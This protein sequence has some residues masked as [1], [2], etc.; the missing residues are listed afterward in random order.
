MS[1]FLECVDLEAPYYIGN[2]P[3]VSSVTIEVIPA[4][5]T[6]IVVS[7]EHVAKQAHQ[8][9]YDDRKKVAIDTK[10]RT[11]IVMALPDE[12]K[13]KKIKNHNRKR[14]SMIA[15]DRDWTDSSNESSSDEEDMTYLCLM[16]KIK[17]VKDEPSETSSSTKYSSTSQV[18]QNFVLRRKQLEKIIEAIKYFN[19]HLPNLKNYKRNSDVALLRK[20]IARKAITVQPPK[21]K[22]SFIHCLKS[23][24]I[25]SNDTNMES[26]Q[27]FLRRPS[28]HHGRVLKP[29]RRRRKR[30]RRRRR[31]QPRPLPLGPAPVQSPAPSQRAPSPTTTP[32]GAPSP[33]STPNRAPSPTQTPNGAPS[34]TWTPKGSPSPKRGPL[35]EPSP[36]L[37]P[38][39]LP[40]VDRLPQEKTEKAPILPPKDEDNSNER[41]LLIIAV[42]SST[43]AAFAILLLFVVCF[44]RLKKRKKEPND[45]RRD[46]RLFPIGSSQ[47]SKKVGSTKD[48]IQNLPTSGASMPGGQVAGVGSLPLPPGKTAPPPPPPSPQS[49]P[50]P[51]P[52]P[53]PLPPHSVPEAPPPPP[54]LKDANVPNPPKNKP[55]PP[56]GLHHRGHSGDENNQ[57]D[58]DA[59]KTKLKPFFWDKVNTSPTRSMVWHDIKA[60]SFQF[61]E[62]MMENL[63]GYGTSNQTKNESGKTTPNIN[64][65]PKLIQLI[66]PKKAQNLAILLKAWNVTT[67]EVIDALKEGNELPVE[68]ISTLLKMA[69]TQ[70]EELKL[71]SYSG[72]VALLGP[73]ERFLKVLV[74][75]PFPFKRLESLLFMSSLQEES[76]SLKE[77]FSILEVAC[78]TL[79]NSRLFHKL[80]EAVL[81]TGNR[82]NVGT[83][84]GGA[85][86]FKLDT[87]LKLSDVKGTDGK[88]TLLSF[89]V[90]EIIRSEGTKVARREMAASQS[91]SEDDQQ[92]QTKEPP[93]YYRRLGLE[94]VS[95]LSEELADVKKAAAID[96]DV[97]TSTVLKLGHMLRKITDFVNNEMKTVEEETG[98]RTFLV[99]SIDHAEA[100]ISW[101]L[102]EEKRIMA[103]VKST[104]DYFHGKSRK[105]EGLHLF[106]VVRDFLVLLD[107]VCNDI[108]KTTAIQARHNQSNSTATTPDASPGLKVRRDKLFPSNKDGPSGYSSSSDDSFSP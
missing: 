2:G 58:S 100:E 62:E 85:Q 51:P 106:V 25:L 69:P 10:A 56:T 61:N 28:S 21:Q 84:R 7:Q 89:V 33:V 5:A 42:A 104:G 72:D 95:K 36:K 46:G 27:D 79:R 12:E 20:R 1:L 102:E 82:M 75:I 57:G 66:E 13:Y 71:G 63:F 30:R 96:G 17:E 45:G 80:L 65:Q 3:Y 87:L 37:S 18:D 19:L 103:L 48:V 31:R 41:K 22:Q 101:L 88:T 68:F 6:T 39:P 70:E 53:P 83:Y 9:T 107:S 78:T 16:A 11:V 14:K 54:P 94:V 15:E 76:S 8:W 91:S 60:G 23:K 73:S 90:Q 32:N 74:D 77:S 35:L 40:D 52:P 98:F 99:D 34:P 38:K 29:R 55:P 67:E 81:K 26:W 93:E 24:R 43:V 44:S 4:T 47:K 92:Q 108:R 64:S 105:D 49:P 50:P 97:L 86:A 59:N